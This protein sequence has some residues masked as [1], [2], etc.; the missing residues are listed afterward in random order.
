[1]A[2]ALPAMQI[3][4]AFTSVA[5]T[6]RIVDPSTTL[7]RLVVTGACTL[8]V[9]TQNVLGHPT[10]EQTGKSKRE[11]QPQIIRSVL[12]DVVPK[13]IEDHEVVILRLG[14]KTTAASEGKND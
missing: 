3:G 1:M 12:E 13:G 14:R 10:S 5:V 4:E 6:I 8:M 11:L 2:C 9:C 7:G